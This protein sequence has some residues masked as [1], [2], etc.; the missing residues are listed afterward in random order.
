M[1]ED[2]EEE[3]SQAKSVRTVQPTAEAAEV[4]Q[5]ALIDV[6]TS[7]ILTKICLRRRETYTTGES[8]K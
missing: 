4:T 5:E 6:R 7:Y 3:H 2:A 8:C 1:A